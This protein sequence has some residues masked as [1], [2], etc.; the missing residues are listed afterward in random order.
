MFKRH[1][2]SGEI[3]CLLHQL[4]IDHAHAGLADRAEHLLYGKPAHT[5]VFVGLDAQRKRRV[6]FE[7]VGY[8]QMDV[9]QTNLPRL[10]WGATGRISSDSGASDSGRT[11]EID[12]S[13]C[14]S[15]R[16]TRRKFDSPS[17]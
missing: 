7:K 3:G 9:A 8:V 17:A 13:S 11:Q 10:K 14:A 15:R 2:L 6:G 12:V 1:G 16:A 5:A 4:P